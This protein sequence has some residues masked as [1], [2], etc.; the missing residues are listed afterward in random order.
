MKG[1]NI[2]A[3]CDNSGGN[4][5]EHITKLQEELQ[6]GISLLVDIYKVG[7]FSMIVLL[8]YLMLNCSQFFCTSYSWHF[9]SFLKFYIACRHECALPRYNANNFFLSS[10]YCFNTNKFLLY[11]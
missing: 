6:K 3:I 2:R 11:C 8:K 9:M 7:D 10:M 4:V 5:E 1:K